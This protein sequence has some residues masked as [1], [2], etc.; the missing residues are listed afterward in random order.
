MGWHEVRQSRWAPLLVV[1]AAATCGFTL[2]YLRRRYSRKERLLRRLKAPPGELPI[3]GHL[4][5]LVCALLALERQRCCC[6]R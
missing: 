1:A 2:S 5:L 4:K 6:M 3:V